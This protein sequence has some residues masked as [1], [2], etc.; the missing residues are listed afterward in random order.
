[1]RE[2]VGVKRRFRPVDFDLHE[3]W[4]IFEGENTLKKLTNVPLTIRFAKTLKVQITDFAANA[5]QARQS[6]RVCL[7]IAD[8]E[9]KKWLRLILYSDVT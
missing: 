1:M 5:R 8:L 2:G 6:R 9:V 4:D 3:R 7:Q